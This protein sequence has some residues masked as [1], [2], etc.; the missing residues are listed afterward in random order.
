MLKT[1]H[2]HALHTYDPTPYG[3]RSG[4]PLA[5][6]KDL[7]PFDQLA[8]RVIHEDA[9]EAHRVGSYA[10]FAYYAGINNHFVRSIEH[11]QGIHTRVSCHRQLILTKRRCR[12]S[13][14]PEVQVRTNPS[15]I[16]VYLI[17]AD[18]VLTFSHIGVIYCTDRAVAN[19]F[20]QVMLCR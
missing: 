4:T 14:I 12:G 13:S 15:Q 18:H 2:D 1:P 20:R 9:S 7:P 6:F 10:V 16:L 3:S 19:G 11:L 17:V 5:Q 8:S